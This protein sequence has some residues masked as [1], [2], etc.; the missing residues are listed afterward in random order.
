[1][2]G[3]LSLFLGFFAGSPT[4]L[5]PRSPG[6]RARADGPERPDAHLQGRRRPDSPGGGRA[7]GA[8]RGAAAGQAEPNAG[9]W[10]SEDSWEVSY[11][12][13]PLDGWLIKENPTK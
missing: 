9:R 3:V 5:G 12:G 1:M 13:T 6:Q 10:F 7:G 8:H 11:A 4:P 2:G